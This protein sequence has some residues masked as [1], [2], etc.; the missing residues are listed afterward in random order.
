VGLS[1]VSPTSPE[2]GRRRVIQ[3]AEDQNG[4]GLP[5]PQT[6]G[7]IEMA[8]SDKR[9]Y[10][11]QQLRAFSDIGRRDADLTKSDPTIHRSGMSAV[12]GLT[13]FLMAE[14]KRVPAHIARMRGG[15]SRWSLRCTIHISRE[16]NRRACRAMPRVAPEL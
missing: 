10:P 16:T 9:K 13:D 8:L 7:W 15:W 1:P 4:T 6:A 3:T 5:K 11:V 2:T 14:R 12:H